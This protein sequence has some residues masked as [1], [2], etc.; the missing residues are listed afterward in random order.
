MGEVLFTLKS[1]LGSWL[2]PFP[3]ALTALLLALLWRRSR[4]GRSGVMLVA[5]VLVL[6]LSALDPIAVSLLK[7]LETQYPKLREPVPGVRYVVVMGAAH[8]DNPLI[9]LTNRPN[10][11]AIY[12]LVEG[13]AQYR[14]HP[15]SR[16]VLSGAAEQ[17]EPHAEILA[18]VARQLGVPEADMVL[19]MGSKDTAEEAQRV[20]ELVGRE[21]LLVVTSAAHMPRTMWWFQRAGANPVAAPTHFIARD[22]GGLSFWL[23]LESIERTSF[24][25][26]EYLGLVWARLTGGR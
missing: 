24:A 9:P 25:L 22:Q 12:R 10:G 11:A 14:R 20:V 17:P 23:R 8:S 6:V 19:Q 3:L 15:G 1:L 7:P 16:L 26:H 18:R 21:G 5:G 4:P 13:V 2:M